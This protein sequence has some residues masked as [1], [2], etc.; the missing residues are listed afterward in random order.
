MKTFIRTALCASVLFSAASM[1]EMSQNTVM[2]GG[3]RHVP[4]P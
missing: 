3:G 1:A 2:V 4:F